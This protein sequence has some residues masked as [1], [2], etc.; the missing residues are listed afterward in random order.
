MKKLTVVSICAMLLVAL[1]G[2]AFACDYGVSR[3]LYASVYGG[4]V[5]AAPTCPTPAAGAVTIIEKALTPPAPAATVEVQRVVIP[6]AP[7]FVPTYSYSVQRAVTFAP[8]VQRQRF[9][10]VDVGHAGV[11]RQR[12][13]VQQRGVVVQRAPVVVKQR[14]VQVVPAQVKVVQ[15]RG[16]FGRV[17]T[18]TTVR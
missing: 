1:A 3:G 7:V 12:V 4:G 14:A 9:F 5:Q 10:S 13:V 17:K 2:P 11:V 8:Y 6:A 18:V 15:T 16:L